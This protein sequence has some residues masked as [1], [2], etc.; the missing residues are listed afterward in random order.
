MDFDVDPEAIRAAGTTLTSTGS[1]FA[2]QVAAFQE[3]AAAYEGAWGDDTIGTYIG[4]AYAAVSGWA[5]ENWLTIADELAVAGADLVL[6][7]DA[8]QEVEDAAAESIDTIKNQ[9]A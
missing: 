8:Y 2:D 9:L 6:T 1:S 7:A 3:R 4:T 5:L